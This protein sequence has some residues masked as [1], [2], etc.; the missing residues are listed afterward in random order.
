MQIHSADAEGNLSEDA[1]PLSK[2]QFPP[3]TPQAVEEERMW[4]KSLGYPSAPFS[5]QTWGASARPLLQSTF[6]LD[7]WTPSSSSLY[8]D[9]I[10]SHLDSKFRSG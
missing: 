10:T 4:F 2:L 7:V 8:P 5:K 3:I 6:A 1:Q 9:W